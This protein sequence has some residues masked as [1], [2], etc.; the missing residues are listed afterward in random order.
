M[1]P[2]GWGWEVGPEGNRAAHVHRSWTSGSSRRRRAR[3]PGVAVCCPLPGVQGTRAEAMQPCACGQ[4]APIRA[5]TLQW[6]G[7]AGTGRGRLAAMEGR[8]ARTQV[9]GARTCVSAWARQGTG[10]QGAASAKGP[11]RLRSADQSWRGCRRPSRGLQA[12]RRAPSTATALYW[13]QTHTIVLIHG[14][15]HPGSLPPG[16]LALRVGHIPRKAGQEPP[17][18][19]HTRCAGSARP[20][21]L[22][23]R[24][25]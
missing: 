13:G 23:L 2:G 1:V 17:Q 24:P 11:G 10:G 16:T 6:E 9:P 8:A 22:R 7:V 19:H 14:L 15:S 21:R 12:G 20:R 4:A 5:R 18:Q 3:R 25:S